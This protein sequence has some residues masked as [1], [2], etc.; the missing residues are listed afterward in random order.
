MGKSRHLSAILFLA[1]VTSL[2]G[3]HTHEH[4]ECFFDSDCGTGEYCAYDWDSGS[5]KCEDFLEDQ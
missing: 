4:D 3:A 5:Y 1:S 2:A